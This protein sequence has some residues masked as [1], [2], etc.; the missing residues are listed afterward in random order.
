MFPVIHQ[1]S[2]TRFLVLLHNKLSFAKNFPE[3]ER[4][5]KFP[6]GKFNGRKIEFSLIVPNQH[7]IAS[8]MLIETI[9]MYFHLEIVFPKDV[10]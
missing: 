1:S 7:Q 2:P 9:P 10:K 4:G 8:Q 5:E 6:N 3:K